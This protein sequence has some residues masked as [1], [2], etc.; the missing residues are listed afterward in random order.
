MK[1]QNRAQNMNSL[2]NEIFML[3]QQKGYDECISFAM[4]ENIALWPLLVIFYREFEF[5]LDIYILEWW[6]FVDLLSHQILCDPSMNDV[7]YV[8]NIW[9]YFYSD[10]FSLQ[11]RYCPIFGKHY[12]IIEMVCS[13]FYPRF[14]IPIPSHALDA[15]SFLWELGHDRLVEQFFHDSYV[16]DQLIIEIE[17]RIISLKC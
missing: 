4:F 13:P 12:L 7:C 5:E 8:G 16:Y 2:V 15:C 17:S 11:M 6:S 14:L 3:C 9:Y 1:A 10:L